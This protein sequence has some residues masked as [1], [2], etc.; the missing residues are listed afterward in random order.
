MCTQENCDLVCL[1]GGGRL[2]ISPHSKFGCHGYV[3][4]KYLSSIEKK[5][6]P[7]IGWLL[8][9][10]NSLRGYRFFRKCS[11]FKG[12]VCYF[13][14]EVVFLTSARD[15]NFMNCVLVM[16][17]ALFTLLSV[18]FQHRNLKLVAVWLTI[19]LK[20]TNF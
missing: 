11:L 8:S 16:N 17:F 1:W 9:P 2:T 18:K 20:I 5:K 4:M 10:P 19:I 14:R 15:F 13:L 6:Q 12:L 7:Y 3:F